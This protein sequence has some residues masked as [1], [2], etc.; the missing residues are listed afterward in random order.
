MLIAD[1]L[2]PSRLG[3]EVLASPWQNPDVH[4][5]DWAGIPVACGLNLEDWALHPGSCEIVGPSAAYSRVPVDYLVRE[6]EAD[7][8]VGNEDQVHHAD[9]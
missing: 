8:R 4:R 5:R 9:C 6:D 7:H 3:Q 2:E 1:L